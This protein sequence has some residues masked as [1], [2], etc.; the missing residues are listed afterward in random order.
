MQRE[1]DL[2][3]HQVTDEN[4]NCIGDSLADFPAILSVQAYPPPPA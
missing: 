1:R 2:R 4:T 3:R